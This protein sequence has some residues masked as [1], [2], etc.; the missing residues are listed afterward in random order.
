MSGP[1]L[2]LA[3]MLLTTPAGTPEPAPDEARWPGVR[4]AIHQL[5]VQWEILDPRETRYVLTRPEDFSCDLNMLRRRHAELQDAPLVADGKRFPDRSTVNELVRFNRAYRKHL[6]QRQQLEVD[7]AD[8]LRAVMWETDRL[9]QIWDAV[10][11]ARCEFY[12]VTVR[13]NQLKKL[14]ELIG[15]EAYEAASLPPN[16]PT[17]RFAEMK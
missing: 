10:R 5:A 7:R 3:A 17:W 15:D 1:D 6:D 12:Y 13:R 4:D 2:I 11:D 14:K 8:A 9:Y 16:V